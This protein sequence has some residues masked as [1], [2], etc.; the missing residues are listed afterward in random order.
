MGVSDADFH[1]IPSL[2]AL[3]IH[4]RPLEFLFLLH[5]VAKVIFYKYPPQSLLLEHVQLVCLHVCCRNII[6]SRNHLLA[7]W[8]GLWEPLAYGP[9]GQR[10]T[11]HF[12]SHIVQACG[13]IYVA[14]N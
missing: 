9:A 14:H 6:Q 8:C 12:Y 1:Q 7:L 2:G 10:D 5:T 13:V 4:C 11:H 3:A